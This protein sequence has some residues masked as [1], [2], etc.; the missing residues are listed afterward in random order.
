MQFGIL[1]L[2]KYEKIEQCAIIAINIPLSE[3]IKKIEN[4]S[5]CLIRT[6]KMLYK[7]T[8]KSKITFI[9]KKVN[10]SVIRNLNS[11]V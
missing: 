4:A 3:T 8:S 9:L 1:R 7:T 5:N 11:F 10:F 6:E 2:I